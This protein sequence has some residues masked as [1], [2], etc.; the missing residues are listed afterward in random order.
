MGFNSAFKGLKLEQCLPELLTAVR[1]PCSVERNAWSYAST[2]RISWWSPPAPPPP[3]LYHSFH[4][5]QFTLRCCYTTLTLWRL[6]SSSRRFE[7]SWCLR[8]QGSCSAGRMFLGCLF[9]PWRWTVI[10]QNYRP[11]VVRMTTCS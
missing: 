11:R 3:C 7:R 8:L 9:D 1:L 2:V 4:N 5:L 6:S 10:S